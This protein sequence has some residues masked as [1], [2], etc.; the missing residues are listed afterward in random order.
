MTDYNIVFDDSPI[1]DLEVTIDSSSL[2]LHPES[3]GREV[4]T[5]T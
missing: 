1:C 3:V 2:S 5:T 4:S